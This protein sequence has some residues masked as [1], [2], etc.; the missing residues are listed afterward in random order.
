MARSGGPPNDLLRAAR[1]AQQSPSGSGRPMSRQELAEAIN[2]YLWRRHRRRTSLDENYIGKL[3]RGHH[4]WPQDMYREAFRAVL[5]VESDADLGFYIIR[6]LLI[7]GFATNGGVHYSSDSD[8]AGSDTGAYRRSGLGDTQ[9]LRVRPELAAAA[10]AK[11]TP[12]I[13]SPASGDAVRQQIPAIRCVLDAH[14][15]PH[16]GPIREIPQLRDEVAA[17]VRMRLQS[18]Y[19]R[20]AIRLPQVL[21][22][23]HRTLETA[24]GQRRNIVAGLLVQAYR[25]ADAVAD[26]FGYYDLSARIIGLMAV[27]ARESGDELAVAAAAYVRA[28][29][30]F[31]NRQYEVGRRMLERAAQRLMPEAGIDSAAAYGALHMRA[32][33]LSARAGMPSKAKDHMLEAAHWARGL[34]DGVYAGTVFG[35]ASVRIHDVALAVDG[36]DPDSALTIAARWQPQPDLPAE[37]RSHFYIDLARAFAMAES[38]EQA[39]DALL[40]ARAIA[41]EHVRDHPQVHETVDGLT[42]GRLRHDVRVRQLRAWIGDAAGVSQPA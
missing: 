14:D 28:E 4:R 13:A 31:A 41:P 21:P 24:V 6:G 3:E 36:G 11:D 37:R 42:R 17:L 23:L 1:E 38:P 8:L 22:E 5:R 15:L 7:N 2:T 20:L 34:P 32:A 16:D 35:P 19:R 27:A 40:T 9:D 25:A 12:V 10:S 29:T 18:R 39:C 30:F 33:V 26:K